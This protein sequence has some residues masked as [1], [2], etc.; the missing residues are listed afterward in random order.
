MF[1]GKRNA[2]HHILFALYLVILSHDIQFCSVL[3]CSYHDAWVN[4]AYVNL[5]SMIQWEHKM[6]KHIQQILYVMIILRE[7]T[8]VFPFFPPVSVPLHSFIA[9]NK[10]V[11]LH[12]TRSKVGKPDRVNLL[13]TEWHSLPTSRQENV[14]VHELICVYIY[15]YTYIYI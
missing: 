9:A 5:N 12:R 10:L 6:Y 2:R 13:E 8:E 4:Q 15:I 11:W 3:F 14:T 7:L 1:C